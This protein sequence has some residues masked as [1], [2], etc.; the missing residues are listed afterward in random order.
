LALNCS[1]VRWSLPFEVVG[2]DPSAVLHDAEVGA[3][4]SVHV[5]AVDRPGF[6]RVL[7]DQ[8]PDLALVLHLPGDDV[9]R[10][11]TGGRG[12]GHH[13]VVAEQRL[14]VLVV[15]DPGAATEG[16]LELLLGL[17]AEGELADQLVDLLPLVAVRIGV[18]RDDE[19]GVLRHVAERVAEPAAGTLAA[20][21]RDEQGDGQD[22]QYW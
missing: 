18:D 3:F 19:C 16:A 12:D 9:R 22:E 2:E 7:L 11:A 17:A 14:D 20:A 15:V 4:R 1:S 13:D 6:G 8:L 21:A 10:R 5:L